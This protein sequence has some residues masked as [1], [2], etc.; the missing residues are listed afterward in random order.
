MLQLKFREEM[1]QLNGFKQQIDGYWD[2]TYTNSRDTFA[3]SYLHFHVWWKLSVYKF[4]VPKY[5][6][7]LESKERFAIKKYLLIIGKKKNM[8]VSSHTITYFST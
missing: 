7:H 8:Q 6:V 1:N 2:K 3:S 5:E 4:N